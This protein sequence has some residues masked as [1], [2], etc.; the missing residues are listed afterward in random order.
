MHDGAAP[1]QEIQQ[2][3]VVTSAT[4]AV[5]VQQDIRVRAVDQAVCPIG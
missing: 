2:A 4:A 1:A 5:P 3:R